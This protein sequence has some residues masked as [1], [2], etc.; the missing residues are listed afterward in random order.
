MMRLLSQFKI[1]EALKTVL[2]DMFLLK[3]C[4]FGSSHSGP[5]RT[6]PYFPCFNFRAVAA[7]G[8]LGIEREYYTRRQPAGLQ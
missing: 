7:S 3:L 6:P 4:L 1:P 5:A 2:T 8:L